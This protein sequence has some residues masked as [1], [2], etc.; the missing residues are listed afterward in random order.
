[1]VYVSIFSHLCPSINPRPVKRGNRSPADV[2]MDEAGPSINPRPVKR[3]NRRMIV[4][5]TR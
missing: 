3:G 5:M 4:R 1:M 2:A